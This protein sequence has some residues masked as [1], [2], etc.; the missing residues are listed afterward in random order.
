MRERRPSD[1]Q[2]GR[3]LSGLSTIPC[4]GGED[5]TQSGRDNDGGFALAGTHQVPRSFLSLV[6]LSS[7]ICRHAGSPVNGR[8]W[9]CV[10]TGTKRR[11][12]EGGPSP[13]RSLIK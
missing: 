9:H 10:W 7:N 1:V 5:E 6:L 2:I 12:S 8:G 11:H 13:V 3:N 4:A